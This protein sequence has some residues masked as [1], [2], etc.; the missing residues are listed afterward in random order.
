MSRTVCMAVKT[1]QV[2]RRGN[3]SIEFY[4]DGK[5][6]YYCYGYCDAMTD[7]ALD[8][9]KK[10]ADYVDGEQ[11]QQQA[12]QYRDRGFELERKQF[13]G[14]RTEADFQYAKAYSYDNAVEIV[15]GGGK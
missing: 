12:D 7:E 14:K 11:L 15:K 2:D 3:K 6:Q 10:C 4:K 13:Q 1:G 9:C 8:V 5:P